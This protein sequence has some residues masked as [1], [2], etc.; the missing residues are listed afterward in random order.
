LFEYKLFIPEK[1][2]G[3]L[4]GEKGKIK[5]L[6]EKKTGTKLAIDK[7]EVTISGEES[8]NA[9]VCKRIIKAIGRGFN[10]NDALKLI[11]DGFVFKLINI[12]DYAR[13]QKDKFRLRG[14]VIGEDGK[15]RKRLE[16]VTD[17]KIIV[18]GKTIGII[19]NEQGVQDALEAIEM[20]LD[21]AQ[22]NSV[23]NFLEKKAK[24]R[25]KKELI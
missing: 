19:G 14:R 3:V 22:T 25:V 4:I 24:K 12:M 5:R 10:P 9:W 16:M 1:R 6:I 20:L 13:N 15:T 8:Y 17:C 2:V 21:G 18:F 11:I 7:E 23:F